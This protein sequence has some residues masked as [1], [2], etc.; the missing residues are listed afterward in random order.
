MEATK[1][2]S[3]P[4]EVPLGQK[5]VRF[6][7]L[8]WDSVPHTLIFYEPDSEGMAELCWDA[9]RSEVCGNSES[10]L[11]S[12]KPGQKRQQPAPEAGPQGQVPRAPPPTPATSVTTT[13]SGKDMLSLHSTSH[14]NL[15]KCAGKS[16]EN[17]SHNTNFSQYNFHTTGQRLGDD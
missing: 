4:K 8:L 11:Q 14:G 16:V 17:W 5:G 6:G 12:G 13:V 3:S 7:R 9:L 2:E 1:E 10:V 15:Y